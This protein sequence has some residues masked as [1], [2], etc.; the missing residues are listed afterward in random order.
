MLRLSKLT[1]YATV[2]LAHMATSPDALHTAAQVAA[3]THLTPATVSKLLKTLTRAGLVSSFRGAQGGYV[4]ARPPARISA[5]DI[6]DAMEGPVAITE[7]STSH[8]LCELESICR[9][10][11]AWQRINR[12]IRRA[13][14]EVTLAEL[15]KPSTFRAPAFNFAATIGS[16]LPMKPTEL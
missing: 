4:L 8:S 9:T 16:K 2:V 15:S 6:I 10:G 12:A 3:C 13:L 1:D 14:G 11:H 7:C 5:A